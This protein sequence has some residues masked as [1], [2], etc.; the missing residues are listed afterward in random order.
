MSRVM[1]RGG[2]FT[3][4]HVINSLLERVN[5]LQ[6]VW[7]TADSECS[8]LV[9]AVCRSQPA[10]SPHTSSTFLPS[11]VTRAFTSLFFF[12]CIIDVSC[13]KISAVNTEINKA[14]KWLLIIIID[15]LLVVTSRP[16]RD[17]LIGELLFAS[18][19]IMSERST[20]VQ[21]CTNGVQ[22]W[23]VIELV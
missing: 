2:A 15:P 9:S 11:C 22:P 7:L 19:D 16:G 21:H 10:A 18:I 5:T 14:T 8:H 3:A 4:P 17:C 1:N 20:L 13:L 6:V 23:T 12:F